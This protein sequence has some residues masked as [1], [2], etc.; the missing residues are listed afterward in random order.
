MEKCSRKPTNSNKI[1]YILNI[2]SD[3]SFQKNAAF[4]VISLIKYIN[5]KFNTYKS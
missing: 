4:W 3:D 5:W 2:K 1:I